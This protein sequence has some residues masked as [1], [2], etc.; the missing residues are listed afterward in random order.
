MG[1][2]VGGENYRSQGPDDMG[3]SK[4]GSLGPLSLLGAPNESLVWEV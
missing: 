3:R 1:V 4:A 2:G